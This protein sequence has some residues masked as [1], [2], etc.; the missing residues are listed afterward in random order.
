MKNIVSWDHVHRERWSYQF[1]E[2]HCHYIVY[3][4][5]KLPDFTNHRFEYLC[6][7]NDNRQAEVAKKQLAM[8][9]QFHGLGAGKIKV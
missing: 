2:K 6:K 5:E 8:I 1:R 9:R 7:E 3:K 4:L